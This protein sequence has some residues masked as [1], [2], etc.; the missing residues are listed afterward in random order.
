L[1]IVNIEKGYLAQ[2]NEREVV[3]RKILLLCMTIRVRWQRPEGDGAPTEM[4][5][6]YQ[7]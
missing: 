5:T 6:L 3:I 2:P 7:C 1:F 4:Y